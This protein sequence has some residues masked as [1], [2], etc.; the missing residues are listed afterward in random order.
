MSTNVPRAWLAFLSLGQSEFPRIMKHGDIF[1]VYEGTGYENH[2]LVRGEIVW[3]K[4]DPGALDEELRLMIDGEP[5]DDNDHGQYQA[6][7]AR[8]AAERWVSD[9]SPSAAE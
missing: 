1:P 3:V 9:L 6:F 7:S 5:C 4:A 2:A 8:E